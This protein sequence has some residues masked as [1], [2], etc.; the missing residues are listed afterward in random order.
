MSVSDIGASAP[1]LHSPMHSVFAQIEAREPLDL[2]RNPARSG[3]ARG[4]MMKAMTRHRVTT[5][6]GASRE[7]TGNGST[8]RGAVRY[9]CTSDLKAVQE[10]IES[11]LE[12][13]DE[14][15]PEAP[16]WSSYAE[17]KGL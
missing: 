17:G 11:E 12:R 3:L 13:K 10:R 15:D 5:D 2:T 8:D 16:T 1:I 4:P 14:P 7:R 6:A 9:R